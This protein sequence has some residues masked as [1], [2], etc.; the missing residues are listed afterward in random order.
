MLEAG[1][2][3]NLH[4]KT[5]DGAARELRISGTVHDPGLA[6]ARQERMGYAYA[7]RDTLAA[8]G[9]PAILTELRVAVRDRPLDRPAVVATARTLAAWLAAHRHPVREID[10]PMPGMHPH[11]LQ[12]VTL[13]VLMLVFAALS[14]LLSAILVASTLSAM[15]VRQ[16]RETA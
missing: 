14:L 11:Q 2:G 3:Q 15:L 12:M 5:P 1:P 4:V 10:V 13:L 7:T 8:L 6:P 16:L 9:E